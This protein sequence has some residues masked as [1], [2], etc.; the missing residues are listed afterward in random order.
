MQP[1]EYFPIVTENG[2]V[3]G[4]ASRK[5]CHSG[6]FILHPVIVPENCIYKNAT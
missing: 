1:I 6:S 5:E 4:K 2:E 3:I